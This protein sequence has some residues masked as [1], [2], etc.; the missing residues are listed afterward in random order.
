MK[1]KVS[2]SDRELFFTR[3]GANTDHMTFG[4]FHYEIANT[5]HFYRFQTA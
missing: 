5:S 1:F 2:F 3:H 4:L